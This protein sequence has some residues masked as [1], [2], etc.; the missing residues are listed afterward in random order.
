VVFFVQDEVSTM[1]R[2][3]I[4]S[5]VF[6]REDIQNVLR[7]IDSANRSLAAHLPL[8]EVGIYRAG[9][10]AAIDAVAKAFDVGLDSQFPRMEIQQ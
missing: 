2:T 6:S 4:R 1:Y 3:R 7:A 10:A 8:A 9:F 5:E